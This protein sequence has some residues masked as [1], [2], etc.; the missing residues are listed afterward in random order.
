MRVTTEGRTS[1]VLSITVS[2]PD[3][4]QGGQ[5]TFGAGQAPAGVI[6]VGAD[7]PITWSGQALTL[8]PDNVKLSLVLGGING[9][10]AAAGQAQHH[11][12]HGLGPEQ[13][14]EPV[15]EPAAGIGPVRERQGGPRRHARTVLSV[16]GR[17]GCGRR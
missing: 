5:Y 4:V 3:Q 15:A 14:G 1:N 7:V 17:R 10:N 16:S 11:R 12:R 9:A 13:L 8:F 2:Q 6:A